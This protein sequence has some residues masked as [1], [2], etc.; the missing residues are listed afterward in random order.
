MPRTSSTV[1]VLLK[2]IPKPAPGAT[3]S[4]EEKQEGSC[5]VRRKPKER[6]FVRTVSRKS[7][8]A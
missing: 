8:R 7:I 3:S 4:L 6:G 5:L 1:K 2:K